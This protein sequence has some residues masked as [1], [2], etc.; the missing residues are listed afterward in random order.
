MCRLLLADDDTQ[1][2]AIRKL[3]LEAA[4]HEVTTAEDAPEARRLLADLLPEVL[5]M[6]LRLP[7]LK[8]GLNLIRC[9]DEQR[10]AVKII[11]VS[12]WIEELS[13]LPEEKLVAS[14][15]GKPFRNDLLLE[16]I[17]AAVSAPARNLPQAAS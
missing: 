15:I 9:V 10:L 13:D 11:V 17:S 16:A 12:G 1:Q 6:D 4:G 5:V 2:L 14:V 3:L 8:D 7:K